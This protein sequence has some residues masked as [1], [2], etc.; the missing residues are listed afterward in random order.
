[1]NIST[2][3][4]VMSYGY[5]QQPRTIDY[6]LRQIVLEK[7]FLG[8]VLASAFASLVVFTKTPIVFAGLAFV[9]EII[10]IIGY[11][12]ARKES[13]IERLYYVFVVSSA[14]L[15]GY[16]LEAI[17]TVVPNG[18]EIIAYAFGTTSLIVGVAYYKAST[19]VVDLSSL[20]RKLM[21]FSMIFIL[22]VIVSI[23]VS[24]GQLGYLLMSIF[25]AFLFSFYLY[26]DLN[27]LMQGQVSSPAR[28]AWSLYWDILLIFKFI[29]RILLSLTRNN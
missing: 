24:F 8:L 25:G 11:F 5:Y 10:A 7:L 6:D 23:F 12:F 21:P 28:M 19:K 29:L 1:M 27:R 13:T 3:Y 16:F 26:F 2:D 22:L 17:L 15:L 4:N 14:V 18:A 9:A 20:A